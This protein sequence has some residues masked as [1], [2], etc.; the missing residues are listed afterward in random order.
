MNVK[1]VETVSHRR[2]SRRSTQELERYLI[3]GVFK[4]SPVFQAMAAQLMGAKWKI[5][6]D[7][8]LYCRL[9]GLASR[10]S[11]SQAFFEIFKNAENGE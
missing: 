7:I 6:M 9:G 3:S 10:A 1:W 2:L 4:M 11:Q 8:M 5:W